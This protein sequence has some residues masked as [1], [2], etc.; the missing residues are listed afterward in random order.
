MF[1]M[2]ILAFPLWFEHN[3]NYEVR[4]GGHD[5]NVGIRVGARCCTKIKSLSVNS[6][7]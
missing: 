1:Y 2:D 5:N 4:F 6:L 7:Q 3:M